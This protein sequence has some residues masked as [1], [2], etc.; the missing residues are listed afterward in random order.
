MTAPQ[1]GERPLDDDGN[2]IAAWLQ[3]ALREPV[4]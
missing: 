4:V 2:A 1:A 3:A